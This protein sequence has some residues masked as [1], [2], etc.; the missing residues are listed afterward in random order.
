MAF[1][2]DV[3]KAKPASGVVLICRGILACHRRGV[4]R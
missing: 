3:G 4:A 2:L 1:L